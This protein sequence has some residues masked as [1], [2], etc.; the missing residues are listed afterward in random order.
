[1]FRA[2]FWVVLPCNSSEHHTR[3]RENLKSHRNYIV[4]ERVHWPALLHAV[5]NIKLFSPLNLSLLHCLCSE[6]FNTSGCHNIELS[7]FHVGNLCCCHVKEWQNRG[8]E[9]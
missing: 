5:T 4:Q 8:P 6:V 7:C 3:R 2:I 9:M 1:M